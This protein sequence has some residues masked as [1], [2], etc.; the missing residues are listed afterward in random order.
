M[1]CLRCHNGDHKTA[2]GKEITSSCDSCHVML[3]DGEEDPE[4]LKTLLGE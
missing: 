1:G 4:I 2:E 3:A